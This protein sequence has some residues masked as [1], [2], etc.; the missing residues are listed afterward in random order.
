MLR[1]WN[2]GII[3]YYSTPPLQPVAPTSQTTST[4]NSNK[5]AVSDGAD[6]GQASILTELA[7]EFN[8]DELFGEADQEAL[9]DAKSLKESRGALK[10]IEEEELQQGRRVKLLG[11]ETSDEEM[12]TEEA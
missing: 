9:A 12:D 7:P 2:T 8:L 3:P 6:V 5:I 1:D 10:F 11:E 4:G